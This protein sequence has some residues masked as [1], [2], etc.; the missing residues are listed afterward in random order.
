M[1]SKT[2]ALQFEVPSVKVI[3]YIGGAVMLV[4]LSFGAPIFLNFT[5][6]TTQFAPLNLVMYIQFFKSIIYL[7]KNI[8][9]LSALPDTTKS[10][11]VFEL[12]FLKS[13]L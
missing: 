4:S 13:L 6:C 12:M 11:N 9:T 1:L 10:G 3:L 7:N 5:S 8:F 2:N